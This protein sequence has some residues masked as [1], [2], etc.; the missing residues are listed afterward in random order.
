[1]QQWYS[2]ILWRKPEK[3]SVTFEEVA[4]RA[5]Q[6]ISVFMELQPNYRPNYAKVG[7]K[8]DAKLFE[9]NYD[10]FC[11]YLNKKA[12]KTSQQ[13]FK[14]LGYTCGF[15]SSL[16][17]GESCGYSLSVGITNK[18][19]VN[20]FVVEFSTSMDYFNGEVSAKIEELFRRSVK[21]FNPYWGCVVN[22]GMKE[23]DN[24]LT[25]DD[26]SPNEIHWLNYMSNS[27]L[28]NLNPKGIKRLTKECKQFKCEDNFIKLQDVALNADVVEDVRLKEYA[29]QLLLK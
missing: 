12:R 10:N 2:L 22:M 18:M 15:F 25:A 5:Y 24:F 23:C 7:K 29:Q 8:R 1:M 16:N 14:D 6:T 21:T 3:E 27:M 20:S 13:M 26:S 28:K 9:W 19:F 4:K 11:D 17:S